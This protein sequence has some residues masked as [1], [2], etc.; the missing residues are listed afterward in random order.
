MSDRIAPLLPERLRWRCDPDQLGFATTDTVPPLDVMVGQDRALDAIAL[1]ITLDAV[2]YNLFVVGPIGTGRMTTV[3]AAVARAAA[4]EPVPSDWGYLHSFQDPYR[5]IAVRLP[6]GLA[7]VLA[8]DLDQFIASCRRDIPRVLESEQYEQRKAT[9]LQSIERQREAL[10][11]GLHDVAARLG[12][13][14]QASPMGIVSV[15]LSATGQPMTREVFELLPEARKAELRAKGQ[16]LQREID[17]VIRASRR[18][19]REA[20][21]RIRALEREA[22]L[23]AVGHLLDALHTRYAQYPR[24]VAHLD[25]IQADLVEHLDEIRSP[26]PA[27]EAPPLAAQTVGQL[28]GQFLERYRVNVLVTHDPSDGAP[29]VFEPNPTYYNLVG[30]LDYRP[31]MLTMLTDFTQIKA[32]AL[33]R[34]N[35]GYLI[36]QA[37]DVL[38]NPF[39]WE[40]L[41]RALRDREVRV[42]NLGEQLSAIP[43]STLKPEPIP[44]DVKIVLIGDLTTYMLL[45][46]LDEDFARLFKVKAQFG[47]AMDRT[48]ETVA[49]YA[50]FVSRQVR[51]QHLLPFAAGAV[52]AIV[53]HGARLIEHQERLT[54]RFAVV[55]EVI[56]EADYWARQARHAI[57][58]AADV[59][60]ALAE[61]E[62][63]ANLLEE[64]IQRAIDEGTIAID[65]TSRAVGQINGLAI[66]D[67]G[68]YTFARPS[69]ITAR[70]ALGED[71]VV[72]VERE[73]ELSGPTHSKGVLILTGY[74][75]GTYAQ[76][77][78]LALS[79]RLTFEQTYS[80]V[81][82]DSASSA[83]LYAL[84]SSLAELPIRQGIAVT[85]SVNQA[86][87]VQAIG[88]VTEKIEGFYAVCKA[89]G[90]TG[91]QGVIIPE[92]N[93]RHLMLKHEIVEAARAG[94][95]H[96][97]AVRTIDEGIE[98]LTGVPAG[99][100]GPDGTYPEGTVHGRVQ[101]RLEAMAR[102]LA[103]F[104]EQVRATLGTDGT[105][106]SRSPATP[107]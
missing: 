42:E 55:S 25:A 2:G 76:D 1:G 105:G 38:V 93:A 51:E 36:L 70:T 89:A 75:L 39:A 84:L 50:G 48:P 54:T 6:P 56:V 101:R 23:S 99:A 11:T 98:L 77:R 33:H 82:G 58:E 12:Y 104:N 94:R 26:R 73:A 30:R 22:A 57:V 32:G 61:R 64:E 16:E 83:E 60:R 69:R 37:R 10:L 29:V 21:E 88:G 20:Q 41:K 49:A 19:E 63:R 13:T 107:S 59:E 87:A 103:R 8:R 62:R 24:V 95:F 35:G 102:S 34:A 18:L 106:P 46:R 96:V 68:D 71:G 5:P 85:G 4:A 67:L 91:E 27:A 53:E 40:A 72:N 31:G 43:V 80:E 47:P 81:D 100:R 90:L 7:P 79:A 92:A 86:G 28:G 78:P 3:R 9:V 66:M 45:L 52:A 17:E 65:V 74:L 44:L 14:V 97:W 15:P